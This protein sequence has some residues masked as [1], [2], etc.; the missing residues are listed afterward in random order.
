MIRLIGFFLLVL[1][2]LG[3]LRQIPLLGGI[4][5]VPFLGFWITALLLSA[6]LSKLAVVAVDRRRFNSLKDQLGA[7]DTAHNQGKL[8]SLLLKQGQHRKAV[9]HLER[10]A[11]GEPDSAEWSYRLGCALLGARRAPDAVVHLRRAAQLEEEYAY[12]AV[13]LRL[14]EALTGSD[15]AEV[16]LE[17]L[18]LFER[19]HGPK[20]E[21]AYRRGLALR[22]LGR[23]DEARTAFR[24]VRELA[25]EVP[26]YQQRAARVWIMR[27]FFAGLR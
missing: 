18:D 24:R 13:Q 11:A 9:P 21:S 7:V 27:A 8:G 1:L 2:L 12:G 17:V 25:S 10:A 14:A 26:R 19:N 4:F 5:Q 3:L 6:A 15:A 22:V 23:R 16:A 20:S